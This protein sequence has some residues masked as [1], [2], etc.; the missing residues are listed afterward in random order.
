[1][2]GNQNDFTGSRGNAKNFLQAEMATRFSHAAAPV[3]T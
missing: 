1:M 3:S 2:S